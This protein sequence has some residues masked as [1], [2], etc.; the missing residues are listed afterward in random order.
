M[1]AGL[2]VRSL[3]G[4]AALSKA[5]PGTLSFFSASTALQVWMERWKKATGADIVWVASKSG[6]EAVN[7]VLAGSTPLAFYGAANFLQYIETGA[8]RPLAV[9]GADRTPQL[10]EVPSLGEL[11]FKDRLPRIWF[12]LFA[13]GGT[14]KAIV[15]RLYR[16]IAAVA[17]ADFRKRRLVDLALEP[18]FNTPEEFAAFLKE[19]RALSGTVVK[20][21]GLA[22]N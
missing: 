8:V 22:V 17:T 19:D 7:G 13:P 12:G 14:P 16:E 10:P 21:A 3:A 6:S 2:G 9:D 4:L 15:D 5:K 1:N 11:G 20:E 18:V